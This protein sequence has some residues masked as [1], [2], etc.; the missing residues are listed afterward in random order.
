MIKPWV[1]IFLALMLSISAL[2]PAP[3]YVQTGPAWASTVTVVLE[4]TLKANNLPQQALMPLNDLRSLMRKQPGFLSDELLQ[5][6][7]PATRRNM[8]MCLAGPPS[9]TGQ[10]CSARQSSASSASMARSTTRSWS[11]LFSRASE[12]P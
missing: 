12:E 5:T 10:P 9:P 2:A 7:M 4:L 11:V 8:F 1:R 6:S 3:A